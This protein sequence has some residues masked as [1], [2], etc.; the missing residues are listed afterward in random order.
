M[1]RSITIELRVDFA[2]TGKKAQMQNL[3]AHV[4]RMLLGGA[5]LLCD[6]K[7]DPQIVVFSDDFYSGIEEINILNLVGDS[8][9]STLEGFGAAIVREEPVSDELLA[10]ANKGGQHKA[11]L[12]PAVEMA[13]PVHNIKAAADK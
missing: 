1:Q 11:E 10:L 12:F 9:V 4:A 3:A 13:H 7:Q 5:K 8:D 2:D 6:G